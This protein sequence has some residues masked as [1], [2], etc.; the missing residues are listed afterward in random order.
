[1]EEEFDEMKSVPRVLRGPYRIAMRVA[2][3]EI[4][5]ADDTQRERGWKLFLLL[6]K[7]LLHRSQ[8]RHDL[9]VQV[10]ETIRLLQPGRADFIVGGQPCVL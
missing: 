2:L 10:V 1:M 8:R 4:E 6:P 7:L 5:S 3:E 9:E